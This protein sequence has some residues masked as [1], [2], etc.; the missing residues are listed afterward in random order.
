MK[1][2]LFSVPVLT[3]FAFWV[4]LSNPAF[5]QQIGQKLFV[6]VKSQQEFES[7][8]LEKKLAIINQKLDYL[9]Q[10]NLRPGYYID[11]DGVIQNAIKGGPSGSGGSSPS[12]GTFRF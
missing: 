6:G 11:K 9:I 3:V 1:K 8:V 2:P 7:L 5:S 4:S 10:Q 12:S